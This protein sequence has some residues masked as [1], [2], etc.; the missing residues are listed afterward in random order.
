MIMQVTVEDV[1]SVKKTLHIEIPQEEVVRE[2]DKAYTELKK[3]AKVK[4]FRPGK[5]P[6]SVLERLFKKDIHA[7]VSSRL[8]QSSFIDAIKETDLKIVGTPELD[9]PEL[10]ASG[11]YKY[12]AA[13]EI[14]PNIAD[15]DYKGLSLQRTNY[16]VSG[17]EI[18]AQLKLLQ[19]NLARYQTIAESRPAE[20]GDYVLI[21]YE[22]FKDG[23]PY[24]ETSRTENFNLK[25]GDGPILKEFDDQLIGMLPGDSRQIEVRFPQDHFN[26]NLAGLDISFQVTLNEIRKE[27]LPEVD[28]ELAKQTG[29]YDS[30]DE[31]EKV[32]TENLEQGYSKRMEQELHEQIY[33]ELISRSVFEVPDALVSME[34]DGII[35]EAERSFAY[36]NLS[37]EELGLSRE[38]I[39]E[40]YRDTAIK[41]VKRHLLLSKLIGQEDLTLSDDELEDALNEMA[42]NFKQPLE[43]IK[44]YYDQNKDKLEFFKHAILEKKAIKLIIDCG[45]IED[46]EP[47]SADAA[48]NGN[49]KTAAE[50]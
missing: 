24:P 22:G 8:I 27:V 30:L 2:L 49:E 7:D 20:I 45:K 44:K 23:R 39:A 9:P 38:S 12:D 5:V 29:Q 21:D 35:E 46:V 6:R 19:K 37:M 50:G 4:G 36:R 33:N 41:Q 47:E 31:L 1:S 11:S 28:D 13:V 42:E 48:G 10:S 18:D 32:I 34:L 26:K 17:K 14:T 16:K 40:K 25:I 43:E 15:I 3:K